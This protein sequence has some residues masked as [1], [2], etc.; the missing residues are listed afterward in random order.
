M[1]LAKSMPAVPNEMFK[2]FM[3]VGKLIP[4]IALPLMFT[5]TFAFAATPGA[6]LSMA[7]PG[8]YGN[9]VMAN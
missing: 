1:N 2:R 7:S 8:I 3:K 5:P 6:A 9:L 4:L